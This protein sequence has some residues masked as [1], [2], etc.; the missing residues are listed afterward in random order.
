MPSGV[1]D[2]LC[3]SLSP[4]SNAAHAVGCQKRETRLNGDGSSVI[5]SLFHVCQG[6]IPPR[7]NSEHVSTK[8]RLPTYSNDPPF[9]HTHTHTHTDAR[10]SHDRRCSG[11]VKN[12]AMAERGDTSKRCFSF[13]F[14]WV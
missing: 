4:S 13:D 14:S 11:P 3:K 10:E 12:T 7:L 9:I 1:P 2:V 5:M 6:I 8:T